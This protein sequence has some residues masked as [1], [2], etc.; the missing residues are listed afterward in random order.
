M[1]GNVQGMAGNAQ[2]M[3]G[4]GW[5]WPGSVQEIAGNGR[6]CAWNGRE[7]AGNSRECEGNTREWPILFAVTVKLF[8]WFEPLKSCFEVT[9][10]LSVARASI[11]F[12]IKIDTT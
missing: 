10:V 8:L 9:N 7:C 5:E 6:E 4:N 12:G 1:A 11:S 2:G 3:A